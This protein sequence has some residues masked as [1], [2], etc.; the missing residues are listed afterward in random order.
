[1]NNQYLRTE[2]FKYS[3][4]VYEDNGETIIL[5]YYDKDGA[6]ELT[7]KLVEDGK[8]F[9]SYECDKEGYLTEFNF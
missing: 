9:G 2:D 7:E 4:K 3:F 8:M 6:K 5:S 1:M